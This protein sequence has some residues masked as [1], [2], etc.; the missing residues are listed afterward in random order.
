[1]RAADGLDVGI[2]WT[3]CPHYLPVNVP[4]GGHKMSGIGEDLGIEANHEFTRLKTHIVNHGGS[5]ST[6]GD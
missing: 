6:W 1:M 4:Y 3:N 5:N 2:I